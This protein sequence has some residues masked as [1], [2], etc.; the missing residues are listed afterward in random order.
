MN[1]CTLILMPPLILNTVG[2]QTGGGFLKC[3]A[4][5]PETGCHE[6]CVCAEAP[7]DS[8]CFGVDT[9]TH[10]HTHTHIFSQFKGLNPWLTVCLCVCCTFTCV[11]R[12]ILNIVF[13]MFH[14]EIISM[15]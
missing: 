2:F 15:I 5:P 6:T 4:V 9:H 8:V 14:K 7:S 1:I 13:I 11:W 10:T 3:L 12:W